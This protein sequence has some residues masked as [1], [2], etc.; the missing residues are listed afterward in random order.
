[1]PSSFLIFSTLGF[2]TRYQHLYY[3]SLPP[4]VN[5]KWKNITI[6]KISFFL[7]TKVVPPCGQA[8]KLMQANRNKENNAGQT[9]ATFFSFA[10]EIKL[11]RLTE[12]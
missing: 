7:I 9:T 6:L 5:G 8:I 2:V 11:S 12:K 10:K 1:M 3:F 4:Q